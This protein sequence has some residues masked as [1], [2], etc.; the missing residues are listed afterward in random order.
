MGKAKISRCICHK[1]D[2]CELKEVADS[3][4]F[5]SVEEFQAEKM[6]ASSC[7]LCIPYLREVLRTGETEFEYGSLYRDKTG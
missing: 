6:A 2:F 3:R 7:G 5:S 4:G 1:K